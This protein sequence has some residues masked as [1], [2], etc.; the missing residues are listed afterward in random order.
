[1]KVAV[2]GESASGL[3]AALELAH[4]GAEVNLFEEHEPNS[5]EKRLKRLLIVTSKIAEEEAI[6]EIGLFQDES[7][8]RNRIGC[9]ELL[10]NGSIARIELRQP[11]LVIEREDLL[12]V[13]RKK[14]RAA[15]VKFFYRHRFKRFASFLPGEESFSAGEIYNQKNYWPPAWA[16]DDPE[17][18]P[19]SLK[20]ENWN[21]ER[22]KSSSRYT[23]PGV[24]EIAGSKNFDYRLAFLV[25]DVAASREKICDADVVIGAD[26]YQSAVRRS[27]GLNPA[28]SL[29]L[30]QAIIPLPRE[31]PP[32]V[33]RIWFL[34]E[35][36]PYFFWLIPESREKGVL[37]LIGKEKEAAHSALR[38]FLERMKFSAQAFEEGWVPCFE[39]RFPFKEKINGGEVYLVGDAAAQVKMTTMGGIYSGLMGAIAAAHG[40]LKN[41]RGRSLEQRARKLRLELLAHKWV[42]KILHGFNSEDYGRLLSLLN[43]PARNLLARVS[44]DELTRLLFGLVLK[45]PRIALLVA[46]ICFQ[47]KL[48]RF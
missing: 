40:I 16:G 14:A 18:S 39:E 11:D 26:G 13:L 27:L 36:T 17:N 9:F 29:F 5:G 12:Q 20:K 6:K 10:A 4:Q 34:P 25:E 35:E 46:K 28:P 22:K 2:V 38:R 43:E 8:V 1:M 24:K 48:F 32:E 23:G 21:E 30:T 7:L 42:R 44:R 33:T 3:L 31:Y 15:G 45:C 19:Y 41:G 37:G 47:R